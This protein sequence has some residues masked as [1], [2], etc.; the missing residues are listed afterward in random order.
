MFGLYMILLNCSTRIASLIL[1]RKHEIDWKKQ[2]KKEGRSLW[3]DR[4]GTAHHIENDE[5]FMYVTDY[6]TGHVIEKNP[7][8]NQIIRD[9]T[10]ENNRKVEQEAINKA[11]CNG[12]TI[13][14]IGGVADDYKP[15]PGYP[16]IKGRIW[17]DSN[18]GKQ[19]V[20]RGIGN[21]PS[22]WYIDLAT[23]LYAFPDEQY[24]KQHDPTW[25]Y[26]NGEYQLLPLDVEIIQRCLDE[27]N[28]KQKKN[29]N[30][31]GKEDGYYVWHNN[32]V[33]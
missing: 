21:P 10:Y 22:W 32:K 9:L 28:A 15:T 23:G 8:T 14:P 7:Y 26:I 20:R 24:I 33:R 16:Y 17:K 2:S 31:Y 13:Y 25:V 12:R 5:A 4:R 29:I 19:Y 11:K 6:N 18:T 1:Q 3:V 27:M 30:K